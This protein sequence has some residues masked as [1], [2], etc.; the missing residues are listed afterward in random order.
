MHTAT[1]GST[2]SKHTAYCMFAVGSTVVL[3]MHTIVHWRT[4]TE[5]TILYSESYGMWLPGTQYC[6][7]KTTPLYSKYSTGSTRYFL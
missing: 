5:V 4:I 3:S 7:R 6:T 1:T 2:S